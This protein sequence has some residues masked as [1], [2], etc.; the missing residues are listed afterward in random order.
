M[1]DA[2]FAQYNTEIYCIY[3]E[4]VISGGFQLWLNPSIFSELSW[5]LV[6]SMF[7]WLHHKNP[8][9]Y[10][11]LWPLCYLFGKRKGF[12]S[13]IQALVWW[14]WKRGHS[15]NLCKWNIYLS[16]VWKRTYE[17]YFITCVMN[18]TK[19]FFSWI[20][21]N[22]CTKNKNQNNQS[23]IHTEFKVCVCAAMVTK[24]KYPTKNVYKYILTYVRWYDNICNR[25]NK[26]ITNFQWNWT[27]NETVSSPHP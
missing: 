22:V 10:H 4:F 21:K 23:I 16:F 14:C 27:K 6:V 13:V 25:R 24:F 20:S 17:L 11:E 19:C 18:K 5:W 3:N 26:Q 9:F 12:Q 1:L 8:F 15:F 2:Y 7:Q